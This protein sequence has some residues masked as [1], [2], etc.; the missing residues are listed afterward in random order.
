MARLWAILSTAAV[1]SAIGMAAQ[2]SDLRGTL[3]PQ[4][5][6]SAPVVWSGPY[7]G[8]SA[9]YAWS[10]STDQLGLRGDQPTGLF[11]QGGLGGVEAGYNF[12]VSRYVLGVE[13]EFDLADI[14]NSKHDQL[15]GD[16]F[17]SRLRYFG[18]LRDRVGY[19]FDRALVYVDGGLAYGG[20][21]SNVNGPIL[22]GSPY[23]FS[24]AAIGYTLGGGV[25]Y[26]LTNNWSIR[27]EYQFMDFGK[28]D[29]ANAAGA[30]YAGIA[31][32]GWATVRRDQYHIFRVGVA[33]TFK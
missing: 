8:A 28:N 29:P 22:N 5:D 33:Y 30:P 23:T 32:G 13:A 12:Q 14:G 1:A 9:G 25:E 15:Y 10:A 27:G 2:A 6:P 17:S 11:S 18:A 7:F 3:E 19:A 26:A 21:S 16:N 24:G 20:L 4:G 31:G